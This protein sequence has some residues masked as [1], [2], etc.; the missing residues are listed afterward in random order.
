MMTQR[1]VLLEDLVIF[2][3]EYGNSGNS[4]PSPEL[5]VNSLVEL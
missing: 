2:S 5:K 3:G 1:N 4:T